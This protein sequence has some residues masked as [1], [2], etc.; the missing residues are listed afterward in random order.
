VASIGIDGAG[1][2]VGFPLLYTRAYVRL[3]SPPGEIAVGFKT[4]QQVGVCRGAGFFRQISSVVLSCSPASAYSA[5]SGLIALSGTE[6][7]RIMVFIRPLASPCSS[8]EDAM[9][10]DLFRSTLR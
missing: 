6:C 9:G 8:R 1:L 2:L 4:H 7:R 10:C 5:R 3:G